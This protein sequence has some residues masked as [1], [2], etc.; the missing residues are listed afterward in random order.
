MLK[1]LKQKLQSM[2]AEIKKYDPSGFGDPIAMQTEWTSS[3][4]GPSA[5]KLVK[6]SSA[7]LEFRASLAGKLV[8]LF[9]TLTG[10]GIM[11]GFTIYKLSR[12]G[13]SFDKDTIVPLLIGLAF[14]L[15]GSLMLYAITAPA[16]FDKRNGFFWKG[17]KA[18]DEVSDRKTIK[19]CAKLDDIHALQLISY[20][21][22]GPKTRSHYRYEL[23]LVLKDAKRIY[24]VLDDKKDKV[25]EDAR[26]L[27]QFLDKPVWDAI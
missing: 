4:G 2:A 3:M 14:T 25:R 10:L 21:C 15:A 5:D 7:R 22:S 8:F 18:P 16:V 27:S 9:F 24:L 26:T 1:K 12:G 11:I 13:L 19:H 6:V 17:R 23:N 20:L